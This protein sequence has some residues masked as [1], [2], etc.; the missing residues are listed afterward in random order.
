[1]DSKAQ[2]LKDIRTQTV[3]LLKIRSAIMSL[4]DGLPGP[5]FVHI[6][7]DYISMHISFDVSDLRSA[8]RLLGSIWHRYS[9]H[10]DDM[11]NRY[12]EYR[13]GDGIELTIIQ[14]ALGATCQRVQVGEKTVPVYKVVCS[15]EQAAA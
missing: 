9:T 7:P 5:I 11:G 13:N 6:S 8:R 2:A 12:F 10:N 4:P 15:A 3:S 14:V 1:M